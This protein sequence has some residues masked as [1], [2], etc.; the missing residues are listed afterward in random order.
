MND[1]VFE[2]RMEQFQNKVQQHINLADDEIARL[3]TYLTT[4][5]GD[6]IETNDQLNRLQIQLIQASQE[7][8]GNAKRQQA[9]LNAKISKMKALFNLKLQEMQTTHANDVTSLQDDYQNAL[10][11]IHKTMKDRVAQQTAPIDDLIKQTKA[12]L[13][14][15][16]STFGSSRRELDEAAVEDIKAVQEVAIAQQKQ[17]EKA[18]QKRVQ[19]RLDSILQAKSRLS[20]CVAT[21]EEMERNH[22]SQ[23]NEYKIKL[24]ALDIQYQAKIKRETDNHNRQLVSLKNKINENEKRNF[25]YQ[26]S[27]HKIERHHK[28]QLNSAVREGDNLQYSMKTQEMQNQ[29]AAKE[30]EKLR[31][32]V[33]K[34]QVLR[35]KL[36]KR[37]NELASERSDNESLKREINRLKHESQMAKRR[38][39]RTTVSAIQT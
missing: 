9:A 14:A 33:D 3:T 8:S 2:R 30:N 21:L 20:D 1:P 15:M 4:I 22:A 36:E 38:Q 23:M 12:K 29:I 26:R 19:E 28:Q 7:S 24:E 34:L 35:E 6:I 25:A 17:L 37:E 32:L 11:N 10:N 31:R 18:I 13:Q 27:I 16:D 39:T 5:K